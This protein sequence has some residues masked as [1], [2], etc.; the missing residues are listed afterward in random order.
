MLK[1]VKPLNQREL[2]ALS[3]KRLLAYLRRL[4]RCEE[5][6]ELSDWQEDKVSPLGGIVFKSSDEWKTQYNLVK[7]VLAKRPNIG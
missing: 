5:S 6:I 1:P 7:A 4:Q 2:E 3:T